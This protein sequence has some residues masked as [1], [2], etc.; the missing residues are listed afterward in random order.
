MPDT[1]D[2]GYGGEHQRLR[3]RWRRE[4]ELG[5]VRCARC[6]FP[7]VPGEPWDLGHNDDDRRFYNGPEHRKCNRQTAA[8][9][10]RTS[11]EW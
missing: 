11:R 5:G 1:V 3:R 9:S 4:V 6:G 7:I 8:R 10:R 2:R